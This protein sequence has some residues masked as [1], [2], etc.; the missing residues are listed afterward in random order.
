MR[1]AVTGGRDYKNKI[2]VFETLD[3]LLY[4]NPEFILVVGDSKGADA[5][6][7]VWAQKKNI[8]VEIFK[9]DWAYY[10][11]SA[12]PIR[13]RRMLESGIDLLVA[14]PGGSGTANMTRLCE[15]SHVKI[16]QV[17]DKDN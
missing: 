17:R 9:A 14:F 16:I 12:G 7:Q 5:H 4:R 11:R 2:K 3:N 15:Q 6:A 8:P 13:N 10:G 1:I